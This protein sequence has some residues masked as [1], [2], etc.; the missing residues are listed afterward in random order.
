MLAIAANKPAAETPPSWSKSR[1][2]PL[3]KVDGVALLTDQPAKT[4]YERVEGGGAYGVGYQF[5]FNVAPNL[6]GRNRDLRFWVPEISDPKS[7]AK[8]SID[9]VI[10]VILPVTRREFPAGLVCQFLQLRANTLSCL[11]GE[12]GG[13]VCRNRGVYPREGLV[14]FLRTR[15]LGAAI[16]VPNEKPKFS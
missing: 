5:V 14:K 1:R 2:T 4:V 3:A 10:N 9:D 11:R 6:K 8:L 12:L 13:K 15:W 16:R 7:T